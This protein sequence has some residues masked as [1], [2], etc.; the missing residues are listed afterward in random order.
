MSEK[1]ASE[2]EK[3]NEAY[4]IRRNNSGSPSA[5]FLPKDSSDEEV[6]IITERESISTGEINWD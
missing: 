1:F 6:L 4:Y 3:N 5:D 2:K